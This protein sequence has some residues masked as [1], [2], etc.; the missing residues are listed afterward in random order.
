MNTFDA[1]ILCGLHM[2]KYGLTEKGWTCVIDKAKRRAGQ[3]RYTK[4][5]IGLSQTYVENS[6]ENAVEDTI[7]HEVAHAILGPGTGHGWAWKL[8]AREIGCSG[9]RLTNVE[10][11]MI[12]RYKGVCEKCGYVFWMHRKPK[13]PEAKRHHTRCGGEVKFDFGI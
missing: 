6:E 11:Q 12:G 7:L 13:R 5:E 3:C 2:E 9:T 4:K 8:K 10:Y 1:K